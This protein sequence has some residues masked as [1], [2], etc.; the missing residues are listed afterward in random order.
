MKKYRKFSKNVSV[1]YIYI[2]LQSS[3]YIYIAIGEKN[4]ETILPSL[5]ACLVIAHSS[6]DFIVKNF[7]TI[8]IRFRLR[9]VEHSTIIRNGKIQNWFLHKEYSS[10]IAKRLLTTPRRENRVVSTQNALASLLL[11]QPDTTTHSK[12]T[13]GFKST[14]NPPPT[15]ELKEFE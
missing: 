5:Q 1:I 4:R 13:Y 14:K 10:T 2:Y 12:D 3:M 11:P 7:R 9:L 15:D 6:G 8:L